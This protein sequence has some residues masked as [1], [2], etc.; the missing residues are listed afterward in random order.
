MASREAP[1]RHQ[2]EDPEM[3]AIRRPQSFAIRGT[4]RSS[5]MHRTVTIVRNHGD[6]RGAVT[7]GGS[8]SD[9]CDLSRCEHCVD[10]DPIFIGRQ[11]EDEQELRLR[12]VR[13]PIVP[14]SGPPSMCNRLHLVGRRSTDDQDHDRGPIAM[15]SWHDHGTFEAKIEINLPQFWEP[16]HRRRESPPRP[17]ETAPMTASFAHE[18]ELIFSLK[19]DVFLSCSLTFDRF[20]KELSEFRGRSLVNRDPLRLDSIVKQLER[21]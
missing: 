17:R 1:D 20:V 2:I 21:D 9:G 12:R 10:R 14:R 18:S 8:S 5:N 11:T 13:S 16:R 4:T 19:T 7:I 3:I 6:A 15:R